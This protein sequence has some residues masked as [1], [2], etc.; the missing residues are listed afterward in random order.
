MS[1]NDFQQYG[2]DHYDQNGQRAGGGLLQKLV[3]AN[4]AYRLKS[5]AFLTVGALVVSAAFAGF[6]LGGGGKSADTANVPVVEGQDYASFKR[7][8]QAGEGAVSDNAPDSTIYMSMRDEDIQETKPVENLLA[9]GADQAQIEA[10]SKQVDQLA[11]DAEAVVKQVAEASAEASSVVDEAHQKKVEN[12]LADA[13]DSKISTKQE[14]VKTVDA[15]ASVELESQ[16]ADASRVE[17]PRMPVTHR[18]GS[19]PETLE[20]VRSVLEKKDA[21]KALNAPATRDHTAKATAKK[22]PAKAVAE[23]SPAAGS[24]AAAGITPGN[25]YVQLGSVTN[26]VGAEGEWGKI[27]KSFSAQLSGVDHRIKSADLGERGIYYRIQAGPMSKESANALCGEIKAQKPGG[28]LV[29]K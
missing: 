29:T 2:F 9:D 11:D 7:A 15:K 20:F 12:L 16:N 19:N 13:E 10:F 14:G 27:K 25:Y 21:H 24:Q 23:V 22:T 3:G 28:C 1:N 26:A 17:P 5:P 8:P 6:L 18:A 4:L